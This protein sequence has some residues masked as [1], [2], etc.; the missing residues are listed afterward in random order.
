MNHAPIKLRGVC[1]H[2][3]LGALGAAFHEKAARRQL[4][5][6]KEMGVNALRTSHNPPAAKL[7]DLCDEMGILVD[8]EAFDMWERAK[9]PYDYARFFPEWEE[10]DVAAWVRRDRAIPA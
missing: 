2:H 9:T 4:R 7:L 10:R 8:D 5:I 6:M 1:L 3:D